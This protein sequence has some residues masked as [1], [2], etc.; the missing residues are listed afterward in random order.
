[1]TGIDGLAIDRTCRLR[2]VALLAGRRVVEVIYE[3]PGPGPRVGDVWVARVGR[4]A[5]GIGGAF[6]DLG[7]GGEGFL[8]TA[9]RVPPEGTALAVTIVALGGGGKRTRVQAA[10]GIAPADG[11][12]RRLREAEPAGLAALRAHLD[13]A[14]VHVEGH[15]LAG[16]ARRW[17]A[18]AGRDAAIEVGGPDLFE[19]LGVEAALDEA[20]ADPIALPDGAHLT[21]DEGRALTAIDVD[22]AGAAPLAADLAAARRIP[23]L[24][25]MRGLGGLIVV[26]FVG[27]KAPED[28]RAVMDSLRAGLVEDALVSACHGLSPLGLAEIA[29]RRLGPSLAADAATAVGVADRV[30]R[31]VMREAAAGRAGAVRASC[32][33]DVA[34]ALDDPDAGGVAALAVAAGRAVTIVPMS[35]WPRERF[36]V[37]VVGP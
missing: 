23:G 11:S 12:P 10:P 35:G 25:R 36:D 13:V 16:Q 24:I 29:R 4:A 18:Q 34:A 8:K 31:R 3:R 21:I 22:A 15:E 30:A 28:R 26:D 6:V 32:A 2:R 1:M 19:V 5:P 27:L 9:R 7:A 37:T 14:T 20:L 33:P 17:L